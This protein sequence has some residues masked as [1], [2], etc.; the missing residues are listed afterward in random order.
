MLNSQK[1]FS[2]YIYKYKALKSTLKRYRKTI[3]ANYKYKYIKALNVYIN[4]IDI[5]LIDIN[6]K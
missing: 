4:L 6:Y 1:K 5:N 2:T 3:R